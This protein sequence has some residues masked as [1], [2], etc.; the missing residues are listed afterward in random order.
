[1]GTCPEL[2]TM[3]LGGVEMGIMNPIEAPSVAPSAGSRGS[4]PA[5][6]ATATA[7]GTM[8]VADAVFDAASLMTMADAVNNAVNSSVDGASMSPASPSPMAVARPVEVASAPI[9][10]P[11]PNS[12]TMPQS[13]C[14][15]SSHDSVKRRAGQWTGSRNSRMAPIM[16]ATDSGTARP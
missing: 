11:P 2:Y 13:M 1:M 7:I 10:M 3:A 6:C 8:M 16:A 5:A 9:E 12:S 14:A 15:A 4:T